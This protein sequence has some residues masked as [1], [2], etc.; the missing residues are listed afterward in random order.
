MKPDGKWNKMSGN[1]RKRPHPDKLQT[2][3][4]ELKKSLSSEENHQKQKTITNIF[5]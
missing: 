3:K 4:K 5:E 2:Y 1:H